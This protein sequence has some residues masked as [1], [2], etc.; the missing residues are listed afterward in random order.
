M[1]LFYYNKQIAN[2]LIKNEKYVQA[3]QILLILFTV[4]FQ[5]DQKKESNIL[6]WRQIKTQIRSIIMLIKQLLYLMQNN[7]I[8]LWKKYNLLSKIDFQYLDVYQVFNINHLHQQV[9]IYIFANQNNMKRWKKPVIKFLYQI[10]KTNMHQIANKKSQRK[11]LK[12]NHRSH[13]CKFQ[14]RINLKKCRSC[15]QNNRTLKL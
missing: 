9:D 11:Y 3:T 6:I 4:M 13:R 8:M 14:Y 5:Q 7:M 15:K 12:N 2:Y 10:V 1:R